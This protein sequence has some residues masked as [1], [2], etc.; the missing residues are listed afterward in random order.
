MQK[1]ERRSYADLF[2]QQ[3]IDIGC[4]PGVEWELP[5]FKI[6][7]F[8]PKRT[9]YCFVVVIWNEGE[10]I[11]NQLKRMKQNAHLA[12]ILIA[13]GNSNDGSTH[14]SFLKE[15][16]VR[17]LMVTEERG[18]C[19]AT[20]MALAY[21]LSQGYEGI[22]T[23]DGNGKDG[24]EALPKFLAELDNGY[25]LVQGS[26]FMKGGYHK[27]TPLYRLLGVRYLFSPVLSIASGYYFSDPTNAF[28]SISRKFLLDKR[29]KPFRKEFVRF[30]LQLYLDYRAGKLNYKVKEIPVSRVYP[31]DGSIPTKIHGISIFVNVWEMFKVAFG[32]YN[33][34]N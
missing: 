23:V 6:T 2:S 32:C 11:K 12:D 24:V 29:V 27:N 19:T 26:R 30:D 34:D 13:D 7:E 18:L 31:D 17:T 25:D 21:A 10:R 16:G 4:D 22:V 28:R 20:R 14:H 3:Y 15:Q 1:I 9:K 8:K 33:V 5:E